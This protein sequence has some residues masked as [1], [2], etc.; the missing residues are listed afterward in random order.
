[1]KRFFRGCRV[2]RVC[3]IV[4]IVEHARFIFVIPANEG[5]ASVLFAAGAEPASWLQKKSVLGF[6]SSVRRT[7]GFEK[8]GLDFS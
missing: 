5:G 2:H 1:S 8:T 6:F 7:D 4:G 3:Q